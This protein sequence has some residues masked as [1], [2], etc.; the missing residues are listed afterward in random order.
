M[1]HGRLAPVARRHGGFTLIE[2]VVSITV[3]AIA[4]GGMLAA[5]SA[6]SANSANTMVSEQA[7]AI[8]AAYLNEVLQKPFGAAD[9]QVTRATLDVVDDYAGLTDVGVHDQTGAAVP[10]LARYTVSIRVG[11]GVLGGVPAAQLREVDVTVS[12]PSGVTVV[13]SGYRTLYP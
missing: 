12:H 2:L 1:T 7:T 8:A 11:A 10:A 13:L 9:G 3:L 4:V 6:V 5:M